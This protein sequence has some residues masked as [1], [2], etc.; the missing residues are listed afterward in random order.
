MV[1]M[2]GLP[3]TLVTVIYPA[4]QAQW[5]LPKLGDM[6]SDQW[7]WFVIAVW[8]ALV[9]MVII[10]ILTDGSRKYTNTIVAEKESQNLELQEQNQHNK[11]ELVKIHQELRKRDEAK[12]V[13]IPDTL[14]SIAEWYKKV[15]DEKKKIKYDQ[16]TYLKV[17]TELLNLN[18]ITDI[19]K[20]KKMS[21]SAVKIID[22]RVRKKMGLEKKDT[23][24][25]LEWAR[26]IYTVMDNNKVGLMRDE[27]SEYV[28][29]KDKLQTQS[30]M[31][32]E[33][34]LYQL[35]WDYVDNG[36]SAFSLEVFTKLGDVDSALKYFPL[37]VRNVL[38]QMDTKLDRAVGSG[39]AQVN[40]ILEKYRAGESVDKE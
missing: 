21:H 34:K 16:Q 4:I 9:L 11:A 29:L 37:D 30:W 23:A 24:R 26:R 25:T 8:Y 33:T 12:V 39:I 2:L 28:A 6:L 17:L 18:S 7:W 19:I 32:S 31:I 15:A 1:T 13:N 3:I 20:V 14:R 5:D 35:I 22:K 36:Y 10:L 27:S 38:E 40:H